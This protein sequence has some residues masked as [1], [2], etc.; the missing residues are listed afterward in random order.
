MGDRPAGHRSVTDRVDRSAEGLPRRGGPGMSPGGLPGPGDDLAERGASIVRAGTDLVPR[1]GWCSDRASA[2]RS[3]KPWRKPRASRSPT[4]PA[5]RVRGAGACGE[6]HPRSSGRGARRRLL[7][8]G[9]LLR[10]ARLDV[11]ALLPRVAKELGA[12]TMVLTAAV[13]GLLPWGSG[14]HGRDPEGPPQHDGRR[15][16]PRVAVPRRYADVHLHDSV[17]DEHLRDLASERPRR[18]ASLRRSVSTRR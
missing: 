6:A 17:Y 7:R 5:S 16:A 13:G 8:T 12:D 14:G 15:P 4:C 1:A 10:G 18:S 9:A 2:P 3:A 11:P